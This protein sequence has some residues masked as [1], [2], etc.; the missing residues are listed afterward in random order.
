[1][2]LDKIIGQD[3]A[4]SHLKRL[5]KREYIPPL[6]F[7]GKEGIGKRETAIA[8]AGTINC[9]NG[10][11]G[12]CISCRS[13]QRHPD[14]M[15]IKDDNGY[16]KIDTIRE[17]IK[18][19]GLKPRYKKRVYIIDNAHF[20]TQEASSSLL[21][22][23]EEAS[24]LFILITNLINSL[25]PTIRSRCFLVRFKPLSSEAFSLLG[26][27]DEELIDMAGGSIKRA[28]NYRNIKGEKEAILL[29]ISSL[30]TQPGFLMID[31]FLKI[32]E[33]LPF[34]LELLLYCLLKNSF[35]SM[36]DEV[37][38]AKE[39][40]KANVNRRLVLEKMV[41]GMINTEHR[42]QNTEHRQQEDKYRA[43]Q[44]DKND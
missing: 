33:R 27:K 12:L 16:I 23:L 29:W 35:Y 10:G 14:I 9:D 37:L 32:D 42:A 39:L 6:I 30:K 38:K 18:E 19:T 5:I 11:C 8:L 26:I 22:T 31:R 17:I 28:L 40:L 2:L 41:L 3:E 15:E 24:A 21:K 7:Y 34:S 4:I 44:S 13:L 36:I 43:Q 25:L 1:M 20:L